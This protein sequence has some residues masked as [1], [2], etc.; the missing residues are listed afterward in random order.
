MLPVSLLNGAHDPA[1]T[2]YPARITPVRQHSFKKSR[3]I[4]PFIK[5][6]NEEGLDHAWS[7]KKL[8]KKTGRNDRE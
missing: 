6:D 7:Y 8:K 1:L 2:G 5:F 4:I 3:W